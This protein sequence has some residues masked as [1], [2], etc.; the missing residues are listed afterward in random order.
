[1]GPVGPI[2]VS[3]PSGR[4][5]VSSVPPKYLA[6]NTNLPDDIVI[7]KAELV[8]KGFNAQFNAHAKTY[9]YTIKI[10]Q[11]PSAIQRYVTYYVGVRRLDLKAMRKAVRYLVGKHDFRAFATEASR[12]PNCIRQVYTINIAKD[13]KFIYIKVRGSGFL[14]NMVRTIVGT[15]LLVGQK[16]MSPEEIKEILES[17]DRRKAGPNVP[18]HGLCLI[19]VEY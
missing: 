12:K 14:Y 6:L 9:L 2:V 15:L 13:E 16:K 17:H 3:T 11:T 19:K 10:G 1:M 8:S 5:Q 7:K 18:A 4:W